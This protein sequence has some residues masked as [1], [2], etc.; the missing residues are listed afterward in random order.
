M[1]IS[2][3]R[4]IEGKEVKFNVFMCLKDKLNIMPAINKFTRENTASIVEFLNPSIFSIA[5]TRLLR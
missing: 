5:I 3:S 2:N 4:L 1:A